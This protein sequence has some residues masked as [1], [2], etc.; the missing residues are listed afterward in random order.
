MY[1]PLVV[2][3]ESKYQ[4]TNPRAVEVLIK[5]TSKNRHINELIPQKVQNKVHG[6]T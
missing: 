3:L 2:D 4:D 6:Y 5:I 1:I